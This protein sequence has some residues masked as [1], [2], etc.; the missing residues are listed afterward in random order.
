MKKNGFVLLETIIVSVI[1]CIILLSL[2]S[3]FSLIYRNRKD[4]MNYNNAF[5]VNTL[6]QLR[7]YIINNYGNLEK[8]SYTKIMGMF[9][10]QREIDNATYYPYNNVIST[11]KNDYNY[12]ASLFNISGLQNVYFI[13]NKKYSIINS[14]LTSFEKDLFT[15]DALRY[16]NRMST[17]KSTK[18]LMVGE[19]KIDNVSK[20]AYLNMPDTI[21]QKY[22]KLSD[23]ILNSEGGITAIERKGNPYFPSVAMG[24]DGMYA[25]T[26]QDGKTYYFRGNVP[27]N[28]V[29]FAGHTWRIV[30]INGDKTIRLVLQDKMVLNGIDKFAYSLKQCTDL[31]SFSFSTATRCAA[32][33]I[34]NAKEVLEKWFDQNINGDNL[35][36]VAK[37]RFCNDTSHKTSSSGLSYGMQGRDSYPS[38]TCT[39]SSP[40]TDGYIL[41]LRGLNVGLLSYDEVILAG[42]NTSTANNAYYLNNV[43]NSFTITPNTYKYS[44]GYT[45]IISFG[46]N[47]QGVDVASE[48]NLHPVI[49]LK[50]DTVT[51][52]GNGTVNNPYVISSEVLYTAGL[53][54]NDKIA[55]DTATST[56]NINL[57]AYSEDKQQKMCFTEDNNSD[58]CNWLPYSES[59][60]TFTL[61]EGAGN[62]TIYLYLKDNIGY[63][64]TYHANIFYKS[65]NL[66]DAILTSAGGINSI[67]SKATPNFSTAEGGNV[68]MFKS[69]DQDGNTYYYRGKVDNNYVDFAGNI[70]RIVRINGDGSIRLVTN[71]N[72]SLFGDNLFSYND[73]S[74]FCKYG[75]VKDVEA[76][77]DCID[78]SK[79]SSKRLLDIWYDLTFTKEE[80]KK[81]IK[82]KFCSDLTYVNDSS[83]YYYYGPFNSNYTSYDLTCSVPNGYLGETKTTE[84]NIGM[85]ATN[86]VILSGMINN[87]VTAANRNYLYSE[88]NS[89]LMSPAY[90]Q[91]YYESSY[92]ARFSDRISD[93]DVTNNSGIRPVIN[94]KGDVVVTGTGT[95][96]NP[97]VIK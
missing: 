47:L 70:W 64:E 28:Y 9:S 15:S 67:S 59:A 22:E 49:N 89:W 78:F 24:D 33:A 85:L 25:T 29:S 88:N 37:G 94:V 36:F 35:Y 84:L 63:I 30:R 58:N 79:S 92:I 60:Q 73:S 21:I 53:S 91:S 5:E 2:Y 68:G 32:F 42:G 97:Y 93:T 44:N 11:N 27:D 16:I 83:N 31:S 1:I 52:S 81:L 51:I 77:S 3:T 71:D 56:R 96:S 55:S 54:I 72:I 23:K 50:A 48:L 14:N 90:Y 46:T 75:G 62:K 20:F 69:T 76:N 10:C 41:S 8:Q 80:K 38:L 26:D 34:S 61:S 19:F 74:D 87:T 6:Y 95:S 12:C 57:Y 18:M 86:E 4:A 40:Y 7:D 45:G 82:G 13:P 66:K 17:D 43:N 39:E 65:E